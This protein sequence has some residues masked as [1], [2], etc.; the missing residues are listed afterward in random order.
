MRTQIHLQLQHDKTV[1]WL[2][3]LLYQPK[4]TPLTLERAKQLWNCVH[5]KFADRKFRANIFPNAQTHQRVLAN[6][7]ESGENRHMEEEDDEKE[8]NKQQTIEFV[9][10][11]F[12]RMAWPMHLSRFLFSTRQPTDRAGRPN[13]KRTEP[14]Q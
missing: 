13:V 10:A 12:V 3:E 1:G 8:I 14:V 9:G 6:E 7:Q 4:T 5:L 2:S 11:L